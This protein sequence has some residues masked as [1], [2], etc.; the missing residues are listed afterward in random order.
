MRKSKKNNGLIALLLIVTIVLITLLILIVTGKIDIKNTLNKLTNNQET[1]TDNLDY[2]ELAKIGSS[3]YNYVYGDYNSE[4]S[5]N[6]LANGK[7]LLDFNKHISNISSAK[8]LILFSGPG[9][10]SMV[11]ILTTEGDVYQYALSN[12]SAKKFSATK[13]DEYSNIQRIVR[14][15]TRK[16]NAG[17]CDYVVLIDN[18]GKYYSLDSFC[19]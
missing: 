3:D 18:K 14:Y 8:D 13:L 6:I 9:V 2:D 12:I 17:G 15:K 7:V 19:V 4:H 10:D 5:V 1:I 11:Y 16:A